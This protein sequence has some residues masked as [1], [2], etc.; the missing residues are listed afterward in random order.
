MEKFSF[1]VDPFLTFPYLLKTKSIK[2]TLDFSG[3]D[4]VFYR[5]TMEKSMNPTDMEK[6]GKGR[7]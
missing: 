2:I 4:E 6:Q 5:K 1:V 7:R 3:I